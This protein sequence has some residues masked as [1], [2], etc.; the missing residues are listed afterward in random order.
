MNPEVKKRWVEALRSGKFAQ[1]TGVLHRAQDDTFCC[2]GV[3]C[4]V[5]VEDGIVTEVEP[6]PY[7]QY[8]FKYRSITDADDINATSPPQAV[9]DWAG[10]PADDPQVTDGDDPESSLMTMNDSNRRTFAEIA[11]A[12]EEQ[13]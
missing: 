11:D 1:G 2:L 7:S 12:I 8:A 13:L 6:G 10:L 9:I 4:A 3:L 5:A